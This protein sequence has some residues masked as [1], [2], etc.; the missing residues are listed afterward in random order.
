MN[1]NIKEKILAL[2][3]ETS[4][5]SWIRRRWKLVGGGYGMVLFILFLTYYVFISDNE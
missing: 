2:A 1:S 5:K 3:I 4:F